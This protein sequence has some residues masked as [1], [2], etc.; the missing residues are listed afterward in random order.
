MSEKTAIQTVEETKPALTSTNASVFT[1]IQCFEDAQRMAKAL[2]ASSIVPASY[3]NNIGDTMLALEMAQRIGATP[4]AVMQS[5]NIIH[6]RPSWSSSF[7]IGALN[8]C[9]RFKS[10]RF[11]KGHSK[12]TGNT[13]QA[14]TYCK[15]TG[16]VLEGPTVTMTMAKAEGW[17]SK[18]GSKWKTMPE[19][20]IMY[21]AAAF[22][23]RLY[24]PD[25]LMGMQTDDEMRDIAANEAKPK[26]VKKA[27][28]TMASQIVKEAV[29]S[30]PEVETVVVEAEIVEAEVVETPA[31][32]KN[33]EDPNDLF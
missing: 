5:L 2:C 11:K 18:S 21:R 3:K 23:G 31:E 26:P 25:I 19:L 1:N 17:I 9:G 14:W 27:G 24:A 28:S 33:Q 12:E 20:M 4:I 7:I 15:E 6:G 30:E 32:N 10:L 29:T 22:F 13:C 8:S 16:D